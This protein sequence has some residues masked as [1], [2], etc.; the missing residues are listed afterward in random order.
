MIHQWTIYLPRLLGINGFGMVI[1][2]FVIMMFLRF[3][4]KL[5]STNNNKFLFSL[6]ISDCLVGLFGIIGNILHYLFHKGLVNKDIMQLCGTLPIFGS[7]F[8]SILSLSLMTADRFIDV[9]YALRYHSIMTEFRANL[10]VVCF[11]WLT[12]AMILITQSAIHL[13]IS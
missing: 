7:F 9:V 6:A 2:F 12:V 5:L 3:H 11:T 4:N 8:M 13:T 1:N 10:L